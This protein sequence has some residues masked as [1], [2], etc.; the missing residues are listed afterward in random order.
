[1]IVDV[2]GALAKLT[3]LAPE[4]SVALLEQHARFL[5]FIRFCAFGHDDGEAIAP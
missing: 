4:V 1:V 2:G 3:G 5:S